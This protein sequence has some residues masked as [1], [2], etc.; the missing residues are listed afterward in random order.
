MR[1]WGHYEIL[2]RYREISG[3]F[4]EISGDFREIMRFQGDHEILGR[5]QEIEGKSEDSGSFIENVFEDDLIEMNYAKKNNC[6]NKD[7]FD[8]MKKKNVLKNL[9]QKKMRT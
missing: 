1:L 2:G 9:T 6:K 3:D 4:R 5:Y 8:E 7:N